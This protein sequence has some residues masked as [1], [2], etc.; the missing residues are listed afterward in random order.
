M[1]D[2]KRSIGPRRIVEVLAIIAVL[3]WRIWEIPLVILWR[4][5]VTL[6]A[7]YWFFLVLVENPRVR[8]RATAA[9][10]AALM[11]I[12]GWGQFPHLLSQFGGPR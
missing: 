6:L 2:L 12:Y 9:A 3:L 8:G 5:W 11:L 1:I 4:D 7:I 10:A